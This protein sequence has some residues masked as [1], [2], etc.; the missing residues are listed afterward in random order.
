MSFGG[1]EIIG[2]ATLEA[3]NARLKAHVAELEAKNKE[4]LSERATLKRIAFGAPGPG[5]FTALADVAAF[6]RGVGQLECRAG[7]PPALTRRLE[8]WR[9]LKEEVQELEDAIIENDVVEVADAY[10][11]I[12]YIVLGSALM[13]IGFD[14]FVSVWEEVHRSNMA[15]IVD[16]ETVRREDGKVLKP[17]GWR[18]PDIASIL[19]RRG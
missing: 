7:D 18:P 15:K 1:D 6:C 9:F 2:D 17:E 14:R 8:R 5:I 12:V 4:L 10:A 19:K 11:D 3:E 13:Q 16:G